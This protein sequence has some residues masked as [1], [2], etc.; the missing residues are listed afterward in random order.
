[1]MLRHANKLREHRCR[2]QV[3]GSQSSSRYFS[4]N[5]G[6]KHRLLVATLLATADVLF[7]VVPWWL[8]IGA[9]AALVP[10]AFVLLVL[11]REVLPG[12]C[13]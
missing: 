2:A 1:M 13:Q 10:L 5:L 9:W 11:C 12:G 3:E 6:W 8:L 7:L 4:E